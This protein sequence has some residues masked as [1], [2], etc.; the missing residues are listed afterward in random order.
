MKY[1]TKEEVFEELLNM[2]RFF[3]DK[4]EAFEEANPQRQWWQKPYESVIDALFDARQEILK[5]LTSKA[6]RE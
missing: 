1:E 2:V 4:Q 5:T 3:D 6:W